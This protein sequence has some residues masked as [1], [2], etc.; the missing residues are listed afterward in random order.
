MLEDEKLGEWGYVAG[1]PDVD[2]IIGSANKMNLLLSILG[3]LLLLWFFVG[4]PYPPLV[5]KFAH[6]L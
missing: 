6:E 5:G 1:G 4:E 2:Q 3:W